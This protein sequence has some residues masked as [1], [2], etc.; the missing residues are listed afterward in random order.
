MSVKQQSKLSLA[1]KSKK[2]TS[3]VLLPNVQDDDMLDVSNKPSGIDRAQLKS[4]IRDVLTSDK[5]VMEDI[6]DV[7]GECHELSS[8]SSIAAKVAVILTE[9]DN[10]IEKVTSKIYEAISLDLETTNKRASQIARQ[11]DTLKINE[12]AL[13]QKLDE[14]EQYSRRNCLLIHGI[15]ETSDEKTDILSLNIMNQKLKLNNPIQPSDL[16]RTHRLG[17]PK[18]TGS[19]TTRPRPII[20]KFISYAKRSDVFRNKRFLKATGTTISE[21]L[22]VVRSGL[23]KAAQSKQSVVNAWSMDGRIICL[24]NNGKRFTITNDE[25]LKRIE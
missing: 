8:Q 12:T 9:S 6:T 15:K 16:D 2:S 14:L 24:L 19:D 7:L 20:V 23:L 5:S 11:V 25:H 21:N 18:Q 13:T 1:A 17:K 22:T 4:A 3:N 10:F